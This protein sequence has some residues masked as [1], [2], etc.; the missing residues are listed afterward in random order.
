MTAPPGRPR[1]RFRELAEANRRAFAGASVPETDVLDALN[2]RHLAVLEQHRPG[3]F[4]MLHLGHARHGH[5]R[6]F[7]APLDVEIPESL[8]AFRSPYFSIQLPEQQRIWCGIVWLERNRGCYACVQWAYTIA[9]M[10]GWR[11]P[12][13]LGELLEAAPHG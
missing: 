11:Q 1:A 2:R 7:C 5:G 3:G 6:P 4:I 8:G 9:D 13:R 12:R 10:R